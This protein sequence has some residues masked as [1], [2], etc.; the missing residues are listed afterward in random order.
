MRRFSLWLPLLS[1][2][3]CLSD[4]LGSALANVLLVGCNPVIDGLIFREPF[5]HWL[6]DILIHTLNKKRRQRF[7]NI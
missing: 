3:L 4:H 6:M 5:S 2:C 1:L 7:S